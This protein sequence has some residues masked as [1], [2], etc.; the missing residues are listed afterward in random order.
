[1][2]KISYLEKK[3][4]TSD[5]RSVENEKASILTGIVKKKRN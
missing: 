4:H 2:G 1:M 3:K 5:A